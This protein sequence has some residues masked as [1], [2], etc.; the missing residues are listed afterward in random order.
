MKEIDIQGTIYTVPEWVKWVSKNKFCNY[1]EVWEYS[2]YQIAG[3]SFRQ[4]FVVPC[5][6]GVCLM[7]QH[8][9]NTVPPE[10]SFLWQVE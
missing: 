9:Y 7:S 10:K 2:P 4:M 6:T 8:V 1:Y 3:G 5:K